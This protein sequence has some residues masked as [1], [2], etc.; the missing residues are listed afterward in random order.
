MVE[1]RRQTGFESEVETISSLV[2]VRF[3]SP[4]L[5]PEKLLCEQ[6]WISVVIFRLTP[7]LFS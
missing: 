2:T 6:R 1:R 5:L 3:L 4:N 7:A